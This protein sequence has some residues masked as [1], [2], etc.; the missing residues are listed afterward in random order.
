M[1]TPSRI[2]DVLNSR[3]EKYAAPLDVTSNGNIIDTVVV[4]CVEKQK[5]GIS[6]DKLEMIART[7]PIA[8]LPGLTPLIRGTLQNRGELLAAVDI[9][10]WYDIE[11]KDGGAFFAVVVDSSG[12]KLGLLI[13]D[14][15]GFRDIAE[16]DLAGSYFSGN[17][18]DGHPIAA[19]TRDL[20]AII[21]VEQ[22]FEHP[23]IKGKTSTGKGRTGALR[24]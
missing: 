7:P 21:D 12:R 8:H 14:I 23:S 1:N 11:S 17:T 22:M 6:I 5:F 13:D 9:A 18:R 10:R 19:T 20:I 4:V 15:L 2:E 16:D 24:Q 3:A